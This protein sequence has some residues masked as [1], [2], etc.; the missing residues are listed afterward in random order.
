MWK[1]VEKGKV[2][3]YTLPEWS[4]H[5][6]QVIMSTR[7][8]GVSKAPY[9]QLNLGLHVGDASEAVIAN[10]RLLLAANRWREE[11]FVSAQQVH[12]NRVLYV[13]A[14]DRGC[15]FYD[16]ESAIKD[17]DGLF[18][19]EQGVLIAT[20]YADCLPLALFHPTL[21][22][23]GLA[24]AGWQG[25]Y[26]NIAAALIGAM[27]AKHDFDPQ[28]LWAATG[29]AIGPCCYQVDADFY[30]RF[31]KR[32]SEAALWFS[33]AEEGKYYFDNEKANV[34]LLQQAGVKKENIS[35]LGLCTA[36]HDDL[37]FSYRKGAGKTGRHGLWGA[38]I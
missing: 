31:L 11:D 23:L 4:A 3:Y 14:P 6:A 7:A 30:Q 33:A 24:H 22:L 15:G 13:G 36:C 8:G 26:R 16:Y 20:F 12:G 34:A 9:D 18:T 28:E 25:T 35:V 1:R 37:F 27:Q 29:A 5:G 10:R 2:I 32:Y 21:K 38:L 19:A 17:T